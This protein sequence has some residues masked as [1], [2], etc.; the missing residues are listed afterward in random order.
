M[1]TIKHLTYNIRF[2]TI[3]LSLSFFFK[4]NRMNE[5]IDKDFPEGVRLCHYD[6]DE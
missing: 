2:L 6:A 3:S 4:Q 5:E 1:E